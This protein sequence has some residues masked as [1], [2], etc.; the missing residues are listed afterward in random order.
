MSELTAYFNMLDRVSRTVDTL[1]RRAAMEAV[2]FT[3]DRFKQ[4]NWVDTTTKP[5][6]KRKPVRGESKRSS[7]RSTLVR[8]GRL[9]RSPRTIHADNNS[10]AIGT[11]VEY[12]Q[13]HNDGFRGRVNQRVRSHMRN[14]KKVK[15]FTRTINLN[16]PERKYIGESVV[17]T[18]R[19]QRMMTAEIT[20]AIKD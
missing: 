20:R 15:R 12:A 8:S 16:I 13:V 17:Q 1:P 6:K 9:R 18:A 14:G 4:Q 5:W 3:K 19:I 2:N 10:A 11:D 7:Q